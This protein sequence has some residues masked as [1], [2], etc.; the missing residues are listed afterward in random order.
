MKP[1]RVLADGLK[2][3]GLGYSGGQITLF[4]TFL[5]ELKKWSR[6][7]SLTSLRKDEDIVIKHFLDSLLFLRGVPHG[8]G[9]LADVGS[10]AGFPG[11]P[12]K[13]MRS[14]ISVS[15]IESSKKKVAFLRH[16]I[17]LLKL[18][19]I[20]VVEGRLED[21]C[22]EHKIDH[23]VIVSR[24]TFKIKDLLQMTCP[25]LGGECLIIL[26]KG[27]AVS[28]ELKMLDKTGYRDSVKEVLRLQLPFTK[29]TRHVIL[30]TCKKAPPDALQEN[31]PGI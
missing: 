23:D 26:S 29:S 4:M 21:L 3:M 6:A 7:Q 20:T 30:L 15:L 17:R 11:I 16:I 5:S 12:I 24:A 27:P 31:A 19:D 9:T 8:T 13:I 14:E 2:A 25:H 18:T 10:G 28:D 22:A 1:D